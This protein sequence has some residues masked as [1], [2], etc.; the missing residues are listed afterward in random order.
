MVDLT[1]NIVLTI[2]ASVQKIFCNV[3]N[4]ST[5]VANSKKLSTWRIPGCIEK[6][7][8][9][10]QLLSDKQDPPNIGQEPRCQS[11]HFG[12][13]FL[14]LPRCNPDKIMQFLGGTQM[15]NLDKKVRSPVGPTQ[16]V[17]VVKQFQ[18]IKQQLVTCLNTACAISFFHIV[19]HNVSPGVRSKGL[20]SIL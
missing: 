19:S 12:P 6:P 8:P 13:K 4:F 11:G 2:H 9:C 16:H 15:A 10:W 5:I 20:P 7:K 14:V 3:F 1:C 18:K 17:F